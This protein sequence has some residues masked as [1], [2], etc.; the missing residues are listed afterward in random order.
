MGWIGMLILLYSANL[1]VLS[2]QIPEAMREDVIFGRVDKL[3]RTACRNIHAT[4]PCLRDDASTTFAQVQN[5]CYRVPSVSPSQSPGSLRWDRKVLQTLTITASIELQRH[6]NRH[7]PPLLRNPA[8]PLHAHTRAAAS[9]SP[10]TNS[11][12]PQPCSLGHACPVRGTH[13]RRAT[14]CRCAS[15]AFW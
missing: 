8:K 14:R 3:L 6:R 11:T 9:A 15:S 12:T 1:V 13:R 5:R 7:W 4:S 10:Q 2:K